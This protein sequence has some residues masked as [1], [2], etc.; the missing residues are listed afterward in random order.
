M[1]K[2]SDHT[3]PPAT[4]GLA[5]RA[6]PCQDAPMAT[7]LETPS[8]CTILVID[9]E[10]PRRTAL[11]RDLAPLDA[12][13]LRIEACAGP[14]AAAAAIRRICAAG[15]CVPLV[16]CAPPLRP[17]AGSGLPAEL[18]P[19]PELAGSRAALIASGDPGGPFPVVADW[20]GTTAGLLE[21]ALRLVTG[22]LLQHAPGRTGGPV[23]T[24]DLETLSTAFVRSEPRRRSLHA[25]LERLQRSF[26]SG[27]DKTDEELDREMLR[28][29]DVALG[30]PARTSFAPGE[31]LLRQDE[32]EGTLWIV[33]SGRVNLCRV[34]D[35]QEVVFH[36]Q[37]TGRVV[38]AMSV[39][40]RSRSFFNARADQP[41]TAIRLTYA[42]LELALQR[43]P[44]FAS[45]FISALTRAMARRNRRSVQLQTEVLSLNKALAA[46]RDQL[47]TALEQLQ[48]AQTLLVQSGKMAT[49]GELSA[50]VA[51]ELNNPVA[52]ILRSTEYVRD[53]LRALLPGLSGGEALARLL[54]I[55]M[56]RPPLSTREERAR[57][58]TLA[59]DLGDEGLARRLVQ[60][61]INRAEDY[62]ALLRE[63]P[64]GTEAERARSLELIGNLGQALRNLKACGDRIGALAS[65]LR[66]Y[67][68]PDNAP[69]D[70][71]DV[72]EGLEDTLRLLNHKLRNVEV[73]RH[74]DPVPAVPG[75]PGELN[76]VWTNLVSNAVQAM[77]GAGRLEV[78]A[79]APPGG[80]VV[81]VSITDSGPGIAPE[82]QDRI[83][84]A[85]FTT[86]KGRV[87]F[88]LGLGLP[89][90]KSIV[91]RHQGSIRVESRPGRTVFTVTLPASPSP[92]PDPERQP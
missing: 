20:P 13:G 2:P 75:F 45:C 88:G 32:S 85:R 57:R 43:S 68:R 52:S 7:P 91:S 49:L 38:G 63:L 42:D 18:A 3:A 37:T 48:Q 51:H 23:P 92:P 33:E 54:D 77:G 11:A 86:R 9:R 8:L 12:L 35:G 60:A 90:C 5:F 39:T 89:I 22:Y 78:A 19:L 30:H 84:E 46:E 14:E 64:L 87:E 6:E 29:L 70:A 74:Y 83:F 16:L 47:A 31:L 1:M 58:D 15:G 40:R 10:E 81:E 24:P 59:A 80:S 62:H 65:S 41:V 26:F 61:G 34:I 17:E 27:R 25:R 69:S 36:S 71:V 44:E 56:E 67:S 55:S 72:R 21:T 66:A 82:N 53:D 4:A 28:S 79:L 76:Q 73:E 50:G